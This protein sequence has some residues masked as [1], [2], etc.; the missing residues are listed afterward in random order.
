M[1]D[2]KKLAIE[3]LNNMKERNSQRMSEETEKEILV[4]KFEYYWP[5]N[6]KSCTVFVF[7]VGCKKVNKAVL[8][9]LNQWFDKFR[10]QECYYFLDLENVEDFDAKIFHSQKKFMEEMRENNKIHKIIL[11]C[12]ELYSIALR[13]GLTIVS[14]RT[15]TRAVCDERKG[16]EKIKKDFARKCYPDLKF[17]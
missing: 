15:P 17:K 9:K 7:V 12:K 3:I 1:S 2:K 6:D 10:H 4:Q 13:V 14:P 5:D 16:F 8:E 11:L